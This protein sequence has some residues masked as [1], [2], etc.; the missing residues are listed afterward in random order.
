MST[1]GLN[2]LHYTQQNAISQKERRRARTRHPAAR[3]PTALTTGLR[4]TLARFAVCIIYTH[5]VKTPEL[6]H[7]FLRGCT[8]F[9]R[10]TAD[11]IVFALKNCS[12]NDRRQ[13]CH[14]RIFWR[15]LRKAAFSGHFCQ[16]FRPPVRPSISTFSRHPPVKSCLE[17]PNLQFQFHRFAYIENLWSRSSSTPFFLY[18]R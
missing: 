15:K 2:L 17:S 14:G 10:K 1:W 4:A 5:H 6:W 8:A 16:N 7:P 9:S 11:A 13:N 3:E 12:R 18:I